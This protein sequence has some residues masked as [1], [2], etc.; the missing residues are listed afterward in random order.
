MIQPRRRACAQE[1]THVIVSDIGQYLRDD[2]PNRVKTE[3][4][5]IYD[6]SVHIRDGLVQSLDS[7]WHHPKPK[8]SSE[9]LGDPIDVVQKAIAWL[10]KCLL[11]KLVIGYHGRVEI[12]VGSDGAEYIFEPRVFQQRKYDWSA[13]D[14]T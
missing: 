5:A 6:F 1:M 12:R 3:K 14:L 13:M 8:E 10:S 4:S 7:E 9:P 2:F 11:A